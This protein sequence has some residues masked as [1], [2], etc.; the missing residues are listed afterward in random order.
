ME[1]GISKICF[2]PKIGI[3]L[4]GQVEQLKTTGKYT[5]LYARSAYIGSKE[6]SILIISWSQTGYLLGIFIG[7]NL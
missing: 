3:R 7:Q 1:I 6:D 2:T 4:I 5:D